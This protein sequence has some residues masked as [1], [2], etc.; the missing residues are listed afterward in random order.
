MLH[1]EVTGSQMPKL[2]PNSMKLEFSPLK[3]WEF[4]EVLRK[5]AECRSG[6]ATKIL[7]ALGILMMYDY[8]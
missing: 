4:G 6:M 3:I 7:M 1:L 5:V 8:C 2:L